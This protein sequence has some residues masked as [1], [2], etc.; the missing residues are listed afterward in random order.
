MTGGCEKG[1]R[2]IQSVSKC[3][4][5]SYMELY[6]VFYNWLVNM[7]ITQLLLVSGI[8]AALASPVDQ[9]DLSR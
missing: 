1:G 5:W 8:A 4:K 7:G 9:L 2:G 3:P 6:H